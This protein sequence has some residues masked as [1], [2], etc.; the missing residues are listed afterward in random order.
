MYKSGAENRQATHS[1]STLVEIQYNDFTEPPER[2]HRLSSDVKPDV[3]GQE[4]IEMT[5]KEDLS[6]DRPL[7]DFR[8]VTK[9]AEKELYIPDTGEHMQSKTAD[10]LTICGY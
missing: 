6:L 10:I 4:I 1:I 9:G 2:H 8:C 5:L 7:R 3:S